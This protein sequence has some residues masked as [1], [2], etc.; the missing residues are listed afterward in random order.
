MLNNTGGTVAAGASPG[1]LTI[2]G[3]YTQGPGGTLQEEIAGTTPGTQFDQLV[4]TGDVT[5]DGT[6]AIL[7]HMFGAAARASR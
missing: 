2:N 7:E 6:L 3:D 1:T 4:V 5:L